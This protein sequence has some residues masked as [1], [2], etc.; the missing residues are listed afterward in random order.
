[1]V[2][3]LF[4]NKV[5]IV[6]LCAWAIAQLS[7]TLVALFQGKG[8]RP[9]F[10]LASGGMPSAHSA[11]VSALT[12]SVALVEGTNSVMFAISAVLALIVMYDA[13]DLRY[14]V[15]RQ[16]VI[17]NR[18]V[19]EIRMRR[20]MTELRSNLREFVGHTPFQVFAGAALGIAVAVVWLTL[21]GV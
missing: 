6:P 8:I 18:L 1:M 12:T 21:S 9:R 10:I 19:E 15:G 7:K 4:F 20:P 17:I 2:A 11:L 3:D 14:A 16:S 13:T 5:L